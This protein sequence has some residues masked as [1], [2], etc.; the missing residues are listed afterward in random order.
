MVVVLSWAGMAAAQS[1]T[2]PAAAPA[3]SSAKPKIALVQIAADRPTALAFAPA[4][5]RF[6][7]LVIHASSGGQACI[8]ELEIYGPDGKANLALAKDGAKPMASSC[9][10]GHAI[11]Q[12]A[13]LNEGQYGNSHSWIAAGTG[14]EWAQI[15]LPK[16]M[17]VAKVVFSRDRQGQYNDRVPVDVEVQLSTDGQQ[18]TT[19]VRVQDRDY[20]ASSLGSIP[21][22]QPATWD[23][24]VQYAFLWERE[25]WYRMSRNDP[26]SPYVVD[27]PALPGGGPYW[28]ELSQLDCLA[29]V[30]RQMDDMLNRLAVRGLDVSVE[31][32]EIAELR[33]RRA[34]LGPAMEDEAEQD[35]YLAARLAKRRLMFRDPEL[36]ALS[37]ILFVKRHPYTPSHNYSDV[38]DSA[39]RPGGGVCVLELPRRD[40][41]IEPV[42]GCV[43]TLFDASKGIARDARA[44]FDAGRIYFAY[45]PSDRGP[46]EAYWHLMVISADG[47]GLRQLTNGPFHDYYPCPL[48]DG[49]V[50]FITTRC[51]CRFL[52]WRPQAFVLFRMEANGGD[53]RPL[54]HANLSEWAV[55]VMRDGRLVWTRSEYVDKG[56]DFGHTLWAIRPDGTQPTLLFGNNTN[57]CYLGGREVPGTSEMVFT[58]ISHGG[59]LNGP[60]GMVD[61]SRGPFAKDGVTNI[62]PDATPRYHMDWAQTNCYRDAAPI[63]RDYFLV[64]HAPADHFG[65]YVI[66]RYGNRELVYLDPAIGATCPTLLRPEPR[67]PV[68]VSPTA[69]A[70]DQRPD[71]PMG[72]LSVADVYRGLEPA[73]PRG[74]VKYLRVCEEV[75]SPLD[76]LPNGAFRNDYDPFQDYYATPTHK[77]A[78]P[79]GWP[80]FVA[81]ASLGIV[82]VEE[83]GSANFYVPAN[84]VIYFQAL[85]ENLNELQ[86]MRSVMQLQPGE[87]RSCIGCHEDRTMAPPLRPATALGREPRRLTPP[88]WGAEAFGFEKVVQPIL[89]AKCATCHDAADKQGINLTG[90]LDGE[91]V[92]ASYRT[93]VSQ[94][95]VHYFD[96]TW[97]REH[98]K[99]EPMS[100]GVLKS[101]LWK[102]LEGDHYGVK[103]TSDEVHRLK[104]WIDLNCPLW[105]DYKFRLDRGADAASTRPEAKSVLLSPP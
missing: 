47:S 13:H 29:R 62:T 5:A 6:V 65:L 54:S 83:D 41:R 28:R 1:P 7:R 60:I 75:R 2:A 45:R 20:R 67:P 73:V 35:L 33:R 95:W 91:R 49:G 90:A 39:F 11:H 50:A 92:P 61:L 4:T 94:G 87:K 63:S 44:T 14:R 81:K 19:V 24:L 17:E 78:G 101:R 80:S 102:T 34:A 9:L 93:L 36:A 72:Q 23:A 16:A 30:L 46:D 66:D 105:P 8:D 71:E 89:T 21:L 26:L 25:T 31:R 96:M 74:K 51:Q 43:T 37:K 12:V 98:W 70:A 100:F 55:S 85:D 52:C 3:K 76:Q 69:V 104:C 22:P 57:N 10:A 68:I 64:S 77:V 99:A 59:D 86:R 27:H 82:P 18:W 48:P 32:R 15:E 103:L 88:S 40:G 84:K 58:L 42:E 79:Y 38:F 56:A 53:I 97:G